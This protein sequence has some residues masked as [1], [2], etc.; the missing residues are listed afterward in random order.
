MDS[1]VLPNRRWFSE[2]R[3]RRSIAFHQRQLYERRNFVVPIEIDVPTEKPAADNLDVV[4][5]EENKTDDLVP[6]VPHAVPAATEAIPAASMSHKVRIF[7]L[8]KH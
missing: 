8:L 2:R 5:T 1:L 6:I 4:V 7:H 3:R